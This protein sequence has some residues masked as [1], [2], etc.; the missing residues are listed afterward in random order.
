MTINDRTRRRL[1]GAAV[2]LACV[3]VAAIAGSPAGAASQTYVQHNLVSSVAGLADHQDADLVNAWGLGAR[4]TSPWWVSD[5]GTDLS[6]LYTA[7]GT[8]LGLKVNVLSGPTGLVANIGSGFPVHQGMLSASAV[9]LFATEDGG[10]L[11]WNPSVSPV[12][13]IEGPA[14]T[15]AGAVF[16]GLAI[17]STPNGD[18]L[19]ATDF[20]NAQVDVWNGSWQPV[21]RV[22]AFD[23][24]NLPPMYAPFGIQNIG[25]GRIVVT[26]ARQGPGR[27]DELDRPGAGFVDLYD[28]A[29]NLITRIAGNNPELNA[30]WGIAQAPPSGFG[31]FSGDLLIGNF[32]DGK[33]HAFGPE[34][35]SGRY[36]PLGPLRTPNG[37]QL[38][39]DGLW[40]LEF[41]LGSL[42]NNGPV[43]TLFFTAGPFHESEGLFGTIVAGP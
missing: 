37:A 18:R 5:N 40:A 28:T 9:F 17:A 11:G 6:T 27:H 30:P 2:L 19:Y 36:Q 20:H 25:G 29:G 7:D 38:A 1:R 41:G 3:G 21:H 35:A 31:K 26:Y 12:T 4:P 13:A 34:D 15:P 24:P 43:T 42:A 14:S 16:K 22:G 33:I 8:K 32:G 39:I 23:D 10:I